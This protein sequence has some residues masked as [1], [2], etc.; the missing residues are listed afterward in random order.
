MEQ[1]PVETK[2]K[3][4]AWRKARGA[5]KNG[6]KE[7]RKARQRHEDHSSEVARR[8]GKRIFFAVFARRCSFT[9]ATRSAR[10]T[11]GR[12]KARVLV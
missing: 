9:V 5:K 3:K 6:G 10:R 8:R 1:S 4:S 11:G 12:K 7:K 2:P